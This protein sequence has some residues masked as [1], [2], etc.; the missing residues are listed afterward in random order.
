MGK[1]KYIKTPEDLYKLF[2]EYKE[3]T[4]SSPRRKTIKG[5]KDFIL[6][7]Q[8]LE[9]PLTISGFR[10]FSY[11]KGLS[12]NHYFSNT[13]GSYDEYRTI[14][15]IIKDEIRQ[16]Q[17]EGGMVGMYNPS[18]TQRLNGLTDKKELDHKGLNLGK[19]YDEKYE[20]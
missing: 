20:D 1:N 7:D 11:K 18:I 16:D 17:I 10:V 14:C 8:E 5:N 13:D 19:A 2:E 3:K 9:V 15:L 12:V 4:K 6:S